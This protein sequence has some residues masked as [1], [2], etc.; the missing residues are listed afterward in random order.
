[1]YKSTAH[2]PVSN[3]S[4]GTSLRSLGP[5]GSAIH[6]IGDFDKQLK[7]KLESLVDG[8]T[9]PHSNAAAELAAKVSAWKQKID[10]LLDGGNNECI[11]DPHKMSEPRE[12]SD[13]KNESSWSG[14]DG[15][16]DEELE[17]SDSRSSSYNGSNNVSDKRN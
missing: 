6:S 11:A 14:S 8:S 10:D 12:L 1:M 2:T 5:A 13:D 15:Q 17:P 4:A 3:C 9:N 7:E 16:E